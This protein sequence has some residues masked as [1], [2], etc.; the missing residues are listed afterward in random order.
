MS[1]MGTCGPCADNLL[2]SL[3]L[4]IQWQWAVVWEY[5]QSVLAVVSEVYSRL[6]D[7]LACVEGLLCSSPS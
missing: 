2:V 5:I 7:L 3:P 4:H 1:L 6:C